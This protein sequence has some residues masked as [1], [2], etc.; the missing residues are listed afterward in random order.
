[1]NADRVKR[2]LKRMA[3]Q[4]AEVNQ[5]GKPMILLGINN[6]GYLVAG[7]L[8]GYLSS[9]Y[10][11]EVRYSRLPVEDPEE[12]ARLLNEAELA[13]KF[14]ILID[15]V[16]FSGRTMFKALRLL[17]DSIELE[18]IYAA[19]LIDRGHRKLPVE[20]RFTGMDLPTKLD[21]HVSVV[22]DEDTIREVLLI[23]S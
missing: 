2:S 15:D 1:M 12:A 14:L 6:R 13:G 20:A 21:E 8:G 11:S 16:I 5:E 10:A 23:T 9:I 7:K 3:Y 4:I 19:V 17:S 18:E 22:T